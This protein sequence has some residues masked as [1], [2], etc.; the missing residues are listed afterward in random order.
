MVVL[1]LALGVDPIFVTTH[2]FA[3]FVIINLALPVIIARLVKSEA[4]SGETPPKDSN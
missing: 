1:A 2:H 4:S 3:R